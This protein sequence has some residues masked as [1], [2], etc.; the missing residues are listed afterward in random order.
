MCFF[1]DYRPPEELDNKRSSARRGEF[2][3]STPEAIGVLLGHIFLAR[4]FRVVLVDF[5]NP[6]PIKKREWEASVSP[7]GAT[8]DF[9]PTRATTWIL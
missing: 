9:L 7:E 6:R 3:S 1:S 5:S 4:R 8:A 2:D